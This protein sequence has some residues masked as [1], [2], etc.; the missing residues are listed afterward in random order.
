[1][2]KKFENFVNEGFLD[3]VLAGIDAGISGYKA[4]RR[5]EQAAEDELNDILKGT[6]EVSVKAQMSV[7]MNR[8]L[9]RIV[10]L[11][12]NFENDGKHNTKGYISQRLDSM[13]EIM[14]R[15]RE[16]SRSIEVS[17]EDEVDWDTLM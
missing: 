16:L 3:N 12:R 13:E 4:N 7:L 2:I 1:M 9:M 8:L 15:L 10:T 17:N 6:S 11:A 5:A 14:D